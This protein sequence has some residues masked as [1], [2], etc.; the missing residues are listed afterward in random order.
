MILSSERE[1]VLEP[2][3]QNFID[4]A[5]N[6]VVQEKKYLLKTEVI[7]NI[8]QTDIQTVPNGTTLNNTIKQNY[9]EQPKNIIPQNSIK[10]NTDIS[11]KYFKDCA[12]NEFKIENGV[13]YSKG[14][15]NSNL[16]F[17]IIT[18]KTNKVVPLDGKIL[19]IFGWNKVEP[20]DNPSED[21]DVDIFDEENVI[22]S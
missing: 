3:P 14:W 16:K 20:T 19:Q 18:E 15:F 17:R 2:I 6:K 21:K 22:N 9:N 12:G 5:R 4:M 11:P 7:D 8:E 1:K 10:Q 13:L